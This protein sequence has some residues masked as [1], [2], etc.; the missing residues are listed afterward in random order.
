[1]IVAVF[2]RIS[3]EYTSRIFLLSATQ[4]RVE[5]SD[6]NDFKTMQQMIHI[7][8]VVKLCT[9][10]HTAKTILEN[11]TGE[12]NTA[13]IKQ[14]KKSSLIHLSLS[15]SELLVRCQDCLQIVSRRRASQ[16][17]DKS[18][19][20]KLICTLYNQFSTG[21][22]INMLFA[23]LGSVC[24]MKNCDRGLENAA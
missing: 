13:N 2:R 10:Y 20:N 8:F 24:R 12:I 16:F 14:F 15:T 9:Q 11:L 19:V 22:K 7:V 4:F 23:S 5:K 18:C 21:K 3:V 17:N 6:S 1:M